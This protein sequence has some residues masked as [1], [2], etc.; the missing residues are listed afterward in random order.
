[1]NFVVVK[2]LQGQPVACQHP[3]H[4]IHRR[5]QQPFGAVDEIH[6]RR[7]A[8]AQIRENW[9]TPFLRP[10]LTAEQYH[11]RAIGQRR[12]VACRQRAFGAFFK[13]RFQRREFFQGQVRAQVVV[14]G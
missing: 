4:G 5:H 3:W 13:G 6:R 8:I 14:A 7:F 1:M 2:I 11:R 9:Q 12:G 10:F